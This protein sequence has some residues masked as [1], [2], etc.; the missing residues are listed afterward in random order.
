MHSKSPKIVL[1]TNVHFQLIVFT[2]I[3]TMLMAEIH[4]KWKQVLGSPTCLYHN[5]HLINQDIGLLLL[6]MQNVPYIQKWLKR[7]G[8][9]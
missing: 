8:T 3:D 4:G 2:D 9:E 1:Q 7:D 6:S 5:V